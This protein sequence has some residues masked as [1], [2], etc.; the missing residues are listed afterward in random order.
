MGG[1]TESGPKGD[2]GRVVR[3]VG[4]T[5]WHPRSSGACRG[6]P[7][8]KGRTDDIGK[9]ALYWATP[10]KG[11]RSLMARYRASSLD[12]D[13]SSQTVLITTRS[14]HPSDVSLPH[15]SDGMDTLS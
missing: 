14:T 13:A 2:T 15:D 4:N 10:E 6:D 8:R 1:E 12:D 7:V 3:T 11:K 9:A 5:I